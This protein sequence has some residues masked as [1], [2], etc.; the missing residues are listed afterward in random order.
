MLRLNETILVD[1]P[2]LALKG[3]RGVFQLTSPTGDVLQ[4]ECGPGLP[5]DVP[6]YVAFLHERTRADLRWEIRKIAE[7]P[8]DRAASD[9]SPG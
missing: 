2:S 9:S 3:E 6:R 8:G 5:P 4:I 7:L 1:N